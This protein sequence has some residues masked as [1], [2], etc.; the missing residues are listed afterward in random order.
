MDEQ[1]FRAKEK[2]DAKNE[3]GVTHFLC[4]IFPLMKTPMH[5]IFINTL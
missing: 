3:R 4:D 1:K 5:H 2:G